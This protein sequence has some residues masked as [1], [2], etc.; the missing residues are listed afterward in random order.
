MFGNVVRHLPFTHFARNMSAATPLLDNTIEPDEIAPTG[1]I[2]RPTNNDR[3]AVVLTPT[4]RGSE[5]ATSQS[6][7]EMG[8][9]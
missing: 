8:V 4:T 6:D 9:F 5:M 1:N 2:N 3:P 7:A